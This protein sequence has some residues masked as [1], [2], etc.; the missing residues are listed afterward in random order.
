MHVPPTPTVQYMILMRNIKVW[1][2]DKQTVYELYKEWHSCFYNFFF[3]INIMKKGWMNYK[4]Q[5]F[6]WDI[7]ANLVFLHISMPYV[8]SVWIF[9]IQ[10]F[11]FFSEPLQMDNSF[12]KK[13]KHIFQIEDKQASECL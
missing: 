13:N 12:L 2:I 7:L 9:L 1:Y 5:L 11:F 8:T 3:S 4:S 10:F 6:V